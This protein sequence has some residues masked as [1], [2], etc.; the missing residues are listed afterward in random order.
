LIYTQ[1]VKF[2]NLQR[3]ISYFFETDYGILPILKLSVSEFQRA[4]PI[5]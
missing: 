2:K 4:T 3:H 1:A 5:S